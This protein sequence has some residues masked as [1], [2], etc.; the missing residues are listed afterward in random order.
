MPALPTWALAMLAAIPVGILLLY[1]LKLRRQVVEVPSTFLWSKSI[2][3]LHVNS[4]FQR[5]RRSLLLLL[6]LLAVVLAALAVLRP[7]YR[8]ETTTAERQIFLLDQSASMQAVDGIDTSATSPTG[9]ASGAGIPSGAARVSRFEAAKK[10]IGEAI[11]AMDNG[12]EAM[13]IG[14]SDRSEVLQGFTSDRKRLRD[15]LSEA[16]VTN[17]TTDVIEALRTAEG[18]TQS[19]RAREVEAPRESGAASEIAASSA[20]TDLLL[21]SDGVFAPATD[22]PLQ[23]LRP[24]Y[25]QVGSQT[26]SNVAILAFS[27]DR[28]P[29]R[30]D[31]IQAFAT[32]ANLGQASAS[33]NA[34]LEL[35]DSIVD[36]EEITLDPGEETGV[37]FTLSGDQASR[38]VLSIDIDDALSIDNVAY[39][40]IPPARSVSVLLVT[41]GNAPLELALSTGQASTL[42]DL[43]V[44][45]PDFLATEA[46]VKRL[47]AQRDDLI[48][49]DRCAPEAMPMTNTF[50]IGSLPPESWNAGESTT[51]VLLI[52]MDRTHPLMQYLELYS[53]L[54]A[55]GR[56]LIPPPG[57]IELLSADGG[58]MLAIAPRDGFQDLVL[59]FEILSS[60]E[61]GTATFNTD[62]QVQRSW[63]V[64]VLNL[65]RHL[66]GATEVTSTRSYQPGEVIIARLPARSVLPSGSSAPVVTVR[67]PDGS[68]RPLT[69]GGSNLFS[70]TDTNQTGVYEVE[71]ERNVVASYSVNLFDRRESGLAAASSVALGYSEV[72]AEANRTPSR[73]EYWR[74]LLL[75]VLGVLAVEWA[76]FARRVA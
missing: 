10:L 47:A 75:I 39:A 55:E 35:D 38:L 63:P 59:G 15:A 34:T 8:S 46:Y 53:L 57:A 71:D 40:T 36:A 58:P 50:F 60:S 54:I 32:I 13:L 74:P 42:C 76:Y 17:R 7:G 56:P 20:A 52:D 3:D 49:F 31:E 2:E 21:F 11:E 23:N 70:I 64:F 37:S 26:A 69:V 61:N 67:F 25:I 27:V 30:A 19:Q 12:Q 22:L 24:R 29:Q 9:E 43:E 73:R 18:L 33:C 41:P 16:S 68:V 51:Q 66:A 1:F 48:V 72:E 5:L 62:W 4:L 6:Q 28:N 44:V 14:F 65:L 45:T